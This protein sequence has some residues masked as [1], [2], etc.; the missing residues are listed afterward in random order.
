M[1]RGTQIRGSWWAESQQQAVFW[2]SSQGYSDILVRA[3]STARHDLTVN[4]GA[5]ALFY[6]QLAVMFRAGV[7]L[8]EA[9][10]LAS[11]SE[12]RNLCGV[13]LSLW[14]GIRSGQSLSRSMRPFTRVFDPVVVGLVAAAESSGRL[15]QTML[16]LAEAQERQYRLRKAIISAVTYPAVLGSCSLGLTALFFVYIFPINRE[17]FGSL[18]MELPWIN[19]VLY[20]GL[21]ALSS[22]FAP[23]LGLASLGAVVVFFR[24][25]WR[26]M[27]ARQQ[28][29]D[30]LRLVPA[31][32]ALITKA[33]ALRMLEILGQLLDGG[34]NVD[35]ALR[36]MLE[37]TV[38]PR[39]QRAIKEIRMRIREGDSFSEAL[40]DS[41]YFPPLVCS[42]LDVGEESGRMVEMAQRGSDICEEDVRVA[43]EQ[44]TQLL[45]PLLLAGAGVLAGF[46]VIT[47]V[48]PMLSL[49]QGL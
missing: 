25:P 44:A 2:L 28:V 12:D 26:R 36:F 17:L 42:L 5:L 22:P 14:D 23:V 4:G 43:V 35:D 40:R 37:A 6:R 1:V 47:S 10:R 15:S 11:Y 18:N 13:C 24:S 9:L 20:S 19:R 31:I 45:E 30:I 33:R 29:E 49:L 38:D 16:R 21:D 32:D 3:V 39:G 8:M 7:P 27:R 46:A 48:M 34:G 41:D